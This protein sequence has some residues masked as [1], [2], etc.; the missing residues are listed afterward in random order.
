MASEHKHLYRVYSDKGDCLASVSGRLRHAAYGREAY[1]A[2]G[3]WVVITLSDD[4]HHDHAV[5]HAILPRRSKFSRKVAGKVLDEQIVAANV[6]TVFIVNALN[7]DFNLRRI[8]RYLTVTWD[9]GATPVIVLTKA[10]LCPDVDAHVDSA[11]SVAP[12]VDVV[13]ISCITGQGL[14]QL[15]RYLLPGRTVALLGSSG[16]GKSTIINR[17]V[18]AEVQRT[19]AVR[20]DDDRGR[21]TTT[22]RELIAIPGKGMIIDTPGMRELQLWAGDDDTV[23]DAF[24][25]ISQL[26]VA[27]KF[28]DCSH[29]SEPGC[30]VRH[31]LREGTLD[32]DRFESFLK[33]QRE[34]AY[35][36]RKENIHEL[37]AE[38]D[39]WKKINMQFRKA[40]KR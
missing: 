3:D 12:G 34:R 35:I 9:S 21:H 14:N 27:C 17:L 25:D 2:V 38:R 30:A 39:R 24:A 8:E 6:D 13:A 22:A 33:L 26:A 40:N 11:Q 4:G 18:G 1:P 28:S 7:H 19:Q 29:G 23:S 10:D 20:T 36:S 5:I 37:L 32:P 31:A 16:A 15:D